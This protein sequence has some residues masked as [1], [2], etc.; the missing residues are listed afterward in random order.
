MDVKCPAHNCLQ[1]LVGDTEEQKTAVVSTNK[2][3]KEE[4]H[5]EMVPIT[6]SNLTQVIGDCPQ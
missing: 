4:E 3:R 6:Y 5:I 1:A 2:S